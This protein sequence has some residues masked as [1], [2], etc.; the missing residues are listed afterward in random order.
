[1]KTK[2]RDLDDDA[3]RD[4]K[5]LQARDIKGMEEIHWKVVQTRRELE[6]TKTL[7]EKNQLTIFDLLYEPFE[8]YTVKR[9]R[10]QIE[11]LKECVFELKRDFNKEFEDL[12]NK[13]SLKKDDIGEKNEIIRDL[14][15]NLNEP[16]EIVEIEPD[17]DPKAILHVAES[18]VKIEKYLT[19]E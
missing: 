2:K 4:K 14:L 7:I 3:N 1:M 15:E 11:L 8:L 19:K 5:G 6:E 18:E 17:E 13:K 12:K 16:D 9:K 10:T